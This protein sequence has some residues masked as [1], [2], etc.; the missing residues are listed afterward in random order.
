[1]TSTFLVTLS[2]DDTD[3]ILVSQDI[4]EDLRASGHDVQEV[5]PWAR[6]VTAPDLGPSFLKPPL[7]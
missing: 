3:L 2:T 4:A 1:M 7:S 5:K 6:P